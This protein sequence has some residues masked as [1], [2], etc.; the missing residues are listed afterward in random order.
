M[1][2]KRIIRK[3]SKFILAS[4]P[5]A[6]VQENIGRIQS[7]NILKGKKIVITCGGFGLGFAMA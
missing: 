5:D 3:I 2:Y 7:G 4:Q 1:G 6:F